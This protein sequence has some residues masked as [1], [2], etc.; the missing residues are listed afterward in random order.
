M[1]MGTMLSAALYRLQTGFFLWRAEHNTFAAEPALR[2]ELFNAEQME[3]HAVE[4]ASRHR[5]RQRP[6]PDRLLARLDDNEEV[7][8]ECC[9][10]FSAVTARSQAGRH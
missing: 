1:T 7:L 9:K 5:L 8:A 2:S 4:L 6:G 3:S 10:M